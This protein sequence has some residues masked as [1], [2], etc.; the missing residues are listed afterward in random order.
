M[1]I[2]LIHRQWTS[3]AVS[4]QL[5]YVASTGALSFLTPSCQQTLPHGFIH[6]HFTASIFP[7]NEQHGWIGRLRFA[8]DRPGVLELRGIDFDWLAC[9]SGGD[10]QWQVFA[11]LKGLKDTDVPGGHVKDCLGIYLIASHPED[12]DPY[13]PPVV[14]VAAYQ[15]V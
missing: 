12:R 13:A 9:P 1:M 5:N 6:G 8:P 11:A 7:S 15:Y 3:G 10:G 2:E 4:P 14:A